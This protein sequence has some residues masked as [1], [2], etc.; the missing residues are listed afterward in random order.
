MRK[1]YLAALTVVLLLASNTSFSQIVTNRGT[2]FW[3]GY[4]S[5]QGMYTGNTQEM[6]LYLST[7]ADTAYV[8]VTLDS[9]GSTPA[10]TWT[11][12]YKIP[13]FTSI[14]TATTTAYSYSTAAGAIG[15][16]PKTGTYDARLLDEGIYR[17]KAIHIESTVPIL[18]YAYIYDAVNSGA[19]VLMPVEAWGIGYISVN[20]KQKYANNC[21][22]WINII[23]REDSTL[24]EVVPSVPTKS[25]RPANVPFYITLHKGQ[26]YQ[27]M[28]ALLSATS[29]EGYELTG[30]M[31]TSFSP[32]KKIAVFGGSTRTFNA[33]STGS[34]G[35]DNDIQQLFPQQSWG[36]KYVT[37]PTS[38]ILGPS[39]FMR[40]IYK[41]VVSDPTTVVLKNGV[42][43]TGL[44]NGTYYSYESTTADIIEAN[45]P[46]MVGQFMSGGP[47]TNAGTVGDPEMFYVS[48]VEQRI[49]KTAFM[50]TNKQNI[51]V[52]YLTMI[53]PT[54]GVD[55]LKIDGIK[56][57]AIA[58]AEKHSYA[59]P[60]YPGHTVLVKKW[61]G[62]QAMCKVESDSSFIGI[63]YG[64][65][66][67]ESYG[68]NIG[69]YID[70]IAPAAAR[71]TAVPVALSSFAVARYNKDVD[72]KWQTAVGLNALRF[73]VERSVDGVAFETIGILAAKDKAGAYNFAD[74]NAINKFSQ[75]KALYYR[76]KM[77][78]KDGKFSHSPIGKIKLLNDH[79]ASITAYPNPFA[80]NLTLSID[81]DEKGT[82]TIMIKDLAG[83][84]LTSQTA[85]IVSGTNIINME[86][87][88]ELGKG[89]YIVTVSVNGST[90]WLKV[91]K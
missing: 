44:I 14:S 61:P 11:R 34:G 80:S 77:V 72:V 21:F 31:V 48:P 35:G 39:Y 10:T 38:N 90:Q 26:I 58:A 15:T 74:V 28:G 50:R 8:T 6:T 88:N 84:T 69:A 68:Y 60:N 54:A 79:Q 51:Q 4:G 47:C 37:A 82:A 66:D 63:T 22:S 91:T 52:S 83:R 30:T 55:S 87:V 78:D 71:L 29:D 41:V 20:S 45:K 65:G 40:N 86:K 43:L 53:V 64:L 62:A 49:K 46:V 9:S 3:V 23:A 85:P 36:K 19:G 73:E 42:P 70:S 16:I 67:V 7:E 2:D 18:A 32:G 57:S 89:V 33:C 12:T 1:I 75:Y 17:K 81:A 56:F 59:H 13:P 76:L 5:H 27:V 25:G 24:V